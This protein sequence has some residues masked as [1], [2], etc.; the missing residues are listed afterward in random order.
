[1]QIYYSITYLLLILSATLAWSPSNGYVPE[2]VPCA[3]NIS[4]VRNASSLSPNETAWLRKRN[5]IVRPNLYTFLKNS[6]SNFT[7]SSIFSDLFTLLTSN[8][9]SGLRNSTLKQ[10]RI[11]IAASGG[12][13]RAMFVGAGMIAAMDN[14]TNGSIEHGLGGLLQSSTYLAG[15]SG[16]SWLVGTLAWNNWTS[17]Q[18]IVNNFTKDDSIWDL[19]NS[20]V[21]PGGVNIFKTSKTWDDISDAV[22]DKQDAGF[23]IS[24]TD[25]WGRALSYNFFPSLYHGGEG[26]TWS[27]IRD[28][29]VF[30][31]AQMPFPVVVSDGRYPGTFIIN[32]NATV[33][34]FN[35]FEMGSW[36]PTLNA[37][38]DV[39][40]LGTNVT[41]G[42]PNVTGKCVA[43]FDNTGFILGTSSSLFNQFLLQLNTT[44]LPDFIQDIARHFLIDLSDNSNDIALYAPNPFKDTKFVN[45]TYSKSLVDSDILYLV[46]GG[47]D[48]ENIPLVPLLQKERDVDVIFALDNSADTNQSWPNGTSLVYTYERQFVEQG[49]DISFPYVPDQNTFVNLG[50]NKRPTFFGC[51]SHNMTNLSS[52]PPLIVYIPNSYHSFESNTSTFKMSYSTKERRSVVQNGFEAAT[53]NNLTDDSQFKA[54]IAC[55]VIRRQQEKNGYNLPL[56][57][58]GCFSRYCWNGTIA[59]QTVN[60]PINTTAMSSFSTKSVTKTSST[61]T[62]TKTGS[63][64]DDWF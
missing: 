32:S 58:E 46:D 47:E 53:M 14:R 41:D 64:W 33:F 23:N 56:E 57:C 13:Y 9:S 5:E 52:I 30:Q 34:E 10:P 16:G 45:R 35:P 28:A 7:N 39:K 63:F 4:L 43:G 6:T 11:A 26:Y 50:L 17:V 62:S 27:T 40:Y 12:G 19:S 36:D 61:S 20:I 54:C 2:M 18:D 1:M 49:I 44:G 22:H 8:S 3:S 38:T 37:F 42:K 48:L 21:N 31:D 24:L 55:A 59:N 25:V 60:I 15:L 51:D 29:Q